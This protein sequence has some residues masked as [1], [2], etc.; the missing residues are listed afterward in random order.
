MSAGYGRGYYGTNQLAP[1]AP[2]RGTSWFT[3]IAVVG[4]GAAVVWLLWP[5]DTLPDQPLPGGGG[6]EREASQ[7]PPPALPSVTEVSVAT[8]GAPEA[9]TASA[10]GAFYKQ[11]EDDARERGFVTVN[12]YEDSVVAT[13]K[14]L[15][16]TGAKVVLAPHLQHLTARVAS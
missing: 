5:R 2:R 12:D 3:V 11:L 1:S 4:L 9:S 14:Q 7:P 13:A 15:Q 6:K 10:T 16:A 8:S